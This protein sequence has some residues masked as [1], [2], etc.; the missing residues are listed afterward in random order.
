[1]DGVQEKQPDDLQS[2]IY[3]RSSGGAVT[4]AWPVWKKLNAVQV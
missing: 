3:R 2:A 4:K 1:M